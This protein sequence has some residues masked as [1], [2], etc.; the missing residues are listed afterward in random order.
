MILSTAKR[1]DV[2]YAA[3]TDKEGRMVACSFSDNKKAAEESAIK[4]LPRYLRRDLTSSPA[5]SHII[6][7]LHQIYSGK[8]CDRLPSVLLAR[9]SKFLDI[10][11]KGTMR[12]PKGKVTT[13]GR[14]ARMAG[15]KKL[16]RAVGNAMARNPLPLVV[17][18][19]RVV[20]STLRVGNYGG[21]GTEKGHGGRVKRELLIREGVRFEGDRISPSCVWNPS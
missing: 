13:Y 10:V 17:P 19:H 8:D 18:C 14:L 12:I 11:Y 5:D 16:A 15:S 2:W 6:D 9:P 1:S 3:V 7:I 4:S 21:G 20:P